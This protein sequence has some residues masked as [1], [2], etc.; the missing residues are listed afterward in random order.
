MNRK[1]MDQTNYVQYMNE[2]TEQFNAL[3][4][5]AEIANR[6]NEGKPTKEE[7]EFYMEARTVCE[8]VI[9]M[10][11]SE[12]AVVSLW[13]S[14]KKRCEEAAAAILKVL[15]P[16]P[17]K[18]NEKSKDKLTQANGGKTGSFVKNGQGYTVTAS[19]FKTRNACKDV[20]AE[21]IERWYKE[22]PKFTLKDVTGMD[23]QKALLM[24]KAGNLGWEQI[25][26]AL[27]ISPAQC[28][29]FY[30]PAGSGKSYLIEAFASEMMEKGFKFIHLLGSEVHQSLVGAAEKTVQIAFQEAI[31]N[32]PCIIFIDEVENVC[33]NRKKAHIEGHEKRL[34][35]SFLEAYNMM[36]YSGKRIIFLGATNFPSQVDEA[37]L[38]RINL[39]RVPL[40]DEASRERYF[41]KTFEVVKVEDGFSFADMA[42][43]TD[44]FSYRDL[45]ERLVP[46]IMETLRKQLIE[47]YKVRDDA[48]NMDQ[49]ATDTAGAKAIHTGELVLTRA[50]F[51]TVLKATTPSVKA[52]IRAELE[53][54]EKRI[55]QQ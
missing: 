25:D 52:D 42:A 11:R 47:R 16:D 4:R 9:N 26:A 35:V 31:D 1:G 55:M 53:A 6:D 37:M 3:L 22:K 28:F 2:K 10:N 40:P 38:D 23:D 32:S 7:G 19:G 44:N 50:L 51:E 17:E 24:E 12:R 13:T 41:R 46:T 30:G 5:H 45:D 49:K 43:Q 29:F 39:V 27:K 36:K 54:F 18:G 20:P 21:T 33:V 48:G 15:S 14:R 34:T 8:E